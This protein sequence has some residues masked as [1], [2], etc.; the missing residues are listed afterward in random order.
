MSE[1]GL[2]YMFKTFTK[3]L[4]IAPFSLSGGLIENTKQGS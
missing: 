3:M 1:S 4:S 2:K